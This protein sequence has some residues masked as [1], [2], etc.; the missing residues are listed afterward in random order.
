MMTLDDGLKR[1]AGEDESWVE[2]A[3]MTAD[4]PLDEA[5][6]DSSEEDE[7]DEPAEPARAEAAE[8]EEDSL[9]DPVRMYLR[10]IGRIPLL[11]AADERALG[12]AMEEGNCVLETEEVLTARLL[13]KPR[14]AEVLAGLFERWARLLPTQAAV[15]REK[16]ITLGSYAELLGDAAFRRAVDGVMDHDLGLA[17]QEALGLAEQ[18]EAERAIAELSTLTSVLGADLVSAASR[19]VGGDERLLP[20]AEHAVAAFER[21]NG[22]VTTRFQSLKAHGR[23][24]KRRLNE[25]NLRLVVSVAKKYVGRDMDLLD[26]IQ[27]GNI[28][29]N[30]AVEKF[31]YRKGWKFSTYATWWVRQAITRAI[32]DQARTIRVP[33]HMIETINK[34]G[35]LSRKFV[36][37]FG[38]EPSIEEIGRFMAISPDKVRE[39][40]KISQE[41]VSLETPIG[42]DEGS[43]L[44]DFVEDEDAI[45]PPEAAA[46]QL[47]RDEVMRALSSLSERERET[48][49]L[50]FGLEDGRTR[51]L[52]EV[53]VEFKLTRERI[54]QIE[55][56]ALRKLREPSRSRRLREYLN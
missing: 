46:H 6:G 49:K 27:E 11:T 43:Y 44:G 1:G 13:R 12:R 33:V 53:G 19:A 36:Q 34:L 37:E 16:Q 38:R 42:E 48:L 52:E 47:M 9:E 41:T 20:P 22:R 30:R 14:P 51:T 32:A 24:A 29:L 55:G 28:G 10:E 26:M 7:L 25:A 8:G 54:R 50:R 23:Q 5:V 31:D 21:L 2:E 35:R 18:A 45:S 17:V 56:K 39:I 3:E 4:A 15:L 40:F